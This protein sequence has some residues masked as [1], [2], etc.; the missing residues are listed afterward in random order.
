MLRVGET[1]EI[2]ENHTVLLQG[3]L[4]ALLHRLMSA[5]S[6][7]SNKQLKFFLFFSRWG[8]A[9]LRFEPKPK[10][11]CHSGPHISSISLTLYSPGS[12]TEMPSPSPLS[13]AK[14]FTHYTTITSLQVEIFTPLIPSTRIQFNS[15]FE[16]VQVLFVTRN[17]LW[18]VKVG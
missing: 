2:R 10:F 9:A 11:G 4:R 1:G 7:L 5:F 13:T 14:L 3:G 15:T 6:A 16:A 17:I 18:Q 12:Y 8:V